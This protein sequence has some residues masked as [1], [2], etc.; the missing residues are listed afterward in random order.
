MNTINFTEKRIKVTPRVTSAFAVRWE[1][2]AE[3]FVNCLEFVG[4]NVVANEKTMPNLLARMD[5]ARLHGFCIDSRESEVR[6]A[7]G[8]YIVLANNE[9]SVMTPEQFRAAYIEVE[10]FDFN[11]AL[12]I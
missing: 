3:S 1:G 5:Y 6:A 12:P 2:T 10:C 9:F 11:G 4:H 7:V 8:Q